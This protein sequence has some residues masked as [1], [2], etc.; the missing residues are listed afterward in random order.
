MGLRNVCGLLGVMGLIACALPLVSAADKGGKSALES[1]PAGWT[2]LM[3][4]KDLKGWKRIPL[5]PDEK[6]NAK[7]PWS[8]DETGKILICDGVG[9]KEMLL[10]T[11]SAL[12]PCHPA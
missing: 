12:A 8:V 10:G 5:P 9:I 1:D 11:L 4:G 3:P 6:L 2:D 7:N